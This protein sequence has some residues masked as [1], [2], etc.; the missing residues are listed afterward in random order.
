MLKFKVT[1]SS[2]NKAELWCLKNVGPRL[3][4]LHNSIG[5]QGWQIKKNGYE[6]FVCIEDDK[7]ALIAMLTLGPL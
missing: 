1:T 3:Y 7:K 6:T 2:L 5:G 4:Y